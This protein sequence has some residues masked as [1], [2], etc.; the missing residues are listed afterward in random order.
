M[1]NAAVERNISVVP[2]P[3]ASSV[4]AALQVAG[5][6]GHAFRFDGYLPVRQGPRQRRLEELATD[7]ATQVFFIPPHKLLRWLPDIREAFGDRH[8]CLAREVTKKFEEFNRGTLSEIEKQYSKRSI[9]GE[10][11][12][13]VAGAS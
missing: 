2:I 10:M 8:A 3:G 13:I 9:K 4:M 1:I 7:P 11:V 12:L 5:F 6:P